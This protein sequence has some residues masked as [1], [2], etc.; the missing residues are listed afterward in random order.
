MFKPLMLATGLLFASTAATAAGTLAVVSFN[1]D[2]D[3]ASDDFIA[4][5]LRKSEGI[6]IWGLSEVWQK[7][8]WPETLRAGAE[9]GAKTEYGSVLGSTGDS[10][11]ML[12]LY[13][14]DRLE[15]LATEELLE[16]RATERQAAPLAAHFRSGG[17]PELML[18]VVNFSEQAARR[19]TQSATL[20]AWAAAQTLPVIAVGSFNFKLDEDGDG[21]AEFDRLLVASGWSWLRPEPNIGTW[22]GDRGR[23]ADNVLL[24]GDARAWR[25]DASVMYPQNNYCPDSVRSS[26]HR[27]VLAR[28]AFDEAAAVPDA[29]M[30]ERQIRP[31]LPGDMNVKTGLD[32]LDA[33]EATAPVSKEDYDALK[34][35]VEELEAQPSPATPVATPPAAP[36]R[37]AAPVAHAVP[38]PAPAPAA[39]PVQGPATTPAPPISEAAAEPSTDYQKLLERIEELEAEVR[40]LREQEASSGR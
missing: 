14:R 32:D 5:Q 39:D 25:A 23:I 40:R 13:R 36:V 11:R 20:G 7:Q 2:S 29:S 4:A 12:I 15:L 28:F 16:A 26:D 37:T 21:D 6:D 3:D 33:D 27:P 38:D 35:R 17:G 10:N 31:F 34:R 19:E 9:K 30:P 22:C 1:V 18:V 8:D 24:G